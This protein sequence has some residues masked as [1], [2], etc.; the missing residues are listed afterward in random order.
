MFTGYLIR[1]D[2]IAENMDWD[3]M[4]RASNLFD[5]FHVNYYTIYL[6]VSDN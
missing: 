3:M 4:E 2:D 1:L 6:N 5:K